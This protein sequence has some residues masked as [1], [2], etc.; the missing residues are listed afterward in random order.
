MLTVTRQAPRSRL[1]TFNDI[2]TV[3][4]IFMG[5]YIVIT[6]LAPSI[7]YWW[8]KRSDSN[9][10]YK[11]QSN[12]T[13]TD[14]PDDTKKKA[15]NL[16]KPP[17]KRLFIP[18]IQLDAEIFDGKTAATLDKGIWR[19]PNTSS[20]DKAGN[21][22]LVAHRFTYNGPAVFYHLDLMKKG[23]RFAV[24]WDGKEYDYEVIETKIVEPTA[25]EIENNTKEPIMTLYTCTPMW[26]AKQ[27]LVIVSKL[28]S[29]T[30]IQ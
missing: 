24:F 3:I 8:Q 29:E 9:Q 25:I 23:H 16:P 14:A 13:Q 26:T 19:R 1:K 7:L 4:V 20:P 15:K 22:V 17:N 5:M 30:P 21:T 2:L 6:P 10:G 11:Y 27:R 18:D 12:L 28:I